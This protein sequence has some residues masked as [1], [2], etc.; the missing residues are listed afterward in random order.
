VRQLAG[1][2]G[3]E[4]SEVS[5][6][7]SNA[8]R[9]TAS[10]PSPESGRR[11]AGPTDS[12]APAT[13]EFSVTD[14]PID[15]LTRQERDV[16]IAIMQ[17]PNEVGRNLV[18]RVIQ[19]TFQNRTLAVVRDVIASSIDHLELPDW[20][21]ALIEG[22]PQSLKGFVQQLAVAPILEREDRI[23]AYCERLARDLIVRDLVQRKAELLGA[24]QRLDKA[25][26]PDRYRELQEQ[27][28]SLEA[29]RQSLRVE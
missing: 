6:A 11:E 15:P 23:P 10:A 7:V 29:E 8:R 3:M 27:T 12:A 22:S 14:L 5:R 28:V 25:V 18:E 13:A 1:W 2:L 20:V 17:H 19:V 16:L 24:M 21:A 9:T 26:E 4:L